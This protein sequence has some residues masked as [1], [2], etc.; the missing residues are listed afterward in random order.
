MGMACTLWAPWAARW[1]RTGMV[2]RRCTVGL[3][4]FCCKELVHWVVM[5]LA[6]K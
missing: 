4:S 1:H 2:G 5:V 6:A 3:A